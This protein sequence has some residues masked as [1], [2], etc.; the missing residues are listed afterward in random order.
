MVKIK[1]SFDRSKGDKKKADKKSSFASEKGGVLDA[2]KVFSVLTGGWRTNKPKVDLN[3]CV[4]CGICTEFCPEASL[5]VREKR[6]QKKVE[7][8]YDFCKGCGICSQ[9]CPFK[10]IKMEKNN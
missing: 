1:N 5:E 10:A 6:G 9:V 3:K 7:V 4:G 8:D 2:K